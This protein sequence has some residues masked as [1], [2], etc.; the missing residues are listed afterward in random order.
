MYMYMHVVHVNVHVHRMYV[1]R[2]ICGVNI[3]I[4]SIVDTLTEISKNF[5]IKTSV[6]T[7]A[8]FYVSSILVWPVVICW[9][10]L[11]SHF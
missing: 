10:I 3:H 8:V 1:H 6:P 5:L 2:L 11:C 9:I 4:Y 7:S